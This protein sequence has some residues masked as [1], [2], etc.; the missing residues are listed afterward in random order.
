MSVNYHQTN[1]IIAKLNI[2]IDKTMVFV[3]KKKKTPNN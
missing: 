1:L 3:D 2:F